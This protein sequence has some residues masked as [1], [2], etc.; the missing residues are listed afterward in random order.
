[1]KSS[2]TRSQVLGE[3]DV[4]HLF[5]GGTLQIEDAQFSLPNLSYP[6]LRMIMAG[7]ESWHRSSMAEENTDQTVRQVTGT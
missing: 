2:A 1:M 5:R 4:L 3:M 7:A 6:A